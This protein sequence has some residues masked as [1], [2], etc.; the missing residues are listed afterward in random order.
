MDY[1]TIHNIKPGDHVTMRVG[2]DAYSYTVL[3]FNKRFVTVQ[4]DYQEIDIENWKPNI[5]PGGFCG[6]CTN[7]YDQKWVVRSNDKGAIDK[8]SVS[9]DGFV[10]SIGSRRNDIVLGAYPFR[11]YNF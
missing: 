4:K 5:V 1:A 8:F 6:H 2:T 9:R 7:N 11:D 10:R 3:S